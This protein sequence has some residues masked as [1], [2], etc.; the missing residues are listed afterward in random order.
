[1]ESNV[2][3]AEVA[4]NERV[5][6]GLPRWAMLSIAALCALILAYMVV[7]MVVY[8]RRRVGD[9]AARRSRGM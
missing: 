9:A 5:E 3:D 8:L 1:M 2:A 4:D 6:G 7:Y